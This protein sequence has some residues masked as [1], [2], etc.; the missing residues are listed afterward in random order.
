MKSKNYIFLIAVASLYYTSCSP[1]LRTNGKN[2]KEEKVFYPRNADTAHFQ[3]LRGF[4]ANTD[5][6]TQ[7]M[8]EQS[9]TGKKDLEWMRKP[10]GVTVERKAKSMWP[11]LV[12]QE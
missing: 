7:S 9:I 8:F 5:I 1:A 4:S 11:I 2:V 3:Y 10:Y 12:F 6:E